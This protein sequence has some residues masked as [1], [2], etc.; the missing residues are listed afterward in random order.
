MDLRH[1]DTLTVIAEEKNFTR[2]AGKLRIT[3]S[4]LSQLVKRIENELGFEVFDRSRSPVELTGPGRLFLPH[5]RSIVQSYSR[6]VTAATESLRTPPLTVGA[7]PTL[8]REVFPMLLA[9]SDGVNM[10]PAPRVVEAPSSELG[11]LLNRGLV[12]VAV[13]S[14]P[15]ALPAR[16]ITFS[17]VASCDIVAVVGPDTVAHSDLGPLT[18]EFLGH[19]PLLL[20]KAGGVRAHLATFLGRLG[21]TYVA[22]ESSSMDSLIGMAAIGTG[23]ALVPEMVMSDAMRR[24]FPEIRVLPLSGGPAPIDTGIGERTHHPQPARLAALR[25][26]TREALTASYPEFVFRDPGDIDEGGSEARGIRRTNE[27]PW[28][29]MTKP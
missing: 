5:A 8:A 24:R 25:E 9:L 4:A 2:A 26:L 22:F 16:G 17:R 13:M 20:P 12:D 10:R 28:R 29:D 3:Q 27:N 18:P 14:S 11:V 21:D 19:Q 6:A 15:P 1:L 23:V 7:A